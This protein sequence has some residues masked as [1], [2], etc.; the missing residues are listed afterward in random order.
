MAAPEGQKQLA[1]LHKCGTEPR[2]TASVPPVA[3][4]PRSQARLA[5]RGRPPA[6]RVA[7][8]AAASFWLATR[9]PPS[10]GPSEGGPY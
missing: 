1:L 6:I 7:A 5:R 4:T 3:N 10:Q 9:C 2:P 8:R